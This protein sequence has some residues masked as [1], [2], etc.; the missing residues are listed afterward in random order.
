MVQILVAAQQ[1]ADSCVAA[2]PLCF[3]AYECGRA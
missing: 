1:D 2:Q 3:L